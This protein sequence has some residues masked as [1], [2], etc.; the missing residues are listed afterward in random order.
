M[1]LRF[2]FSLSAD[3]GFL[4]DAGPTTSL[5]RNG[6]GFFEFSPSSHKV[7]NYFLLFAFLARATD[8]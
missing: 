8:P 1:I 6:T 7:V 2:G 3:A 4:T 5:K